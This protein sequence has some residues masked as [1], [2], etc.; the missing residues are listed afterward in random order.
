MIDRPSLKK[1]HIADPFSEDLG[2]V[3]EALGGCK[4]Q[5]ARRSSQRRVGTVDFVACSPIFLDKIGKITDK[6]VGS[7]ALKYEACA[8]IEATGRSEERRVGK[9]CVSTCRSRW[10]RYNEKK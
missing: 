3:G 2:I 5:R 4:D 10:S 8:R 1:V 7:D 9:A 6:F